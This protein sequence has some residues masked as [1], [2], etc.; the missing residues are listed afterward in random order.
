MGTA[1]NFN[2]NINNNNTNKI[3]M[4]AAAGTTISIAPIATVSVNA[5]R[6]GATMCMKPVALS[7]QHITVSCHCAACCAH[8]TSFPLANK[9]SPLGS[10]VQCPYISACIC[11]LDRNKCTNGTHCCAKSCLHR[12]RK[13]KSH[14][15]RRLSRA[16]IAYR[17]TCQYNLRG[18]AGAHAHH[19][20]TF[21]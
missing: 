7:V 18:G 6:R 5:A 4:S 21:Y 17:A 14:Q 19:T 20:R 3:A 15:E 2:N 10:C 9:C 1:N 11:V 16:I 12:P 8:C 13:S